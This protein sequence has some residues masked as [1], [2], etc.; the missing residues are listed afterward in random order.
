MSRYTK[1]DQFTIGGHNDENEKIATAINDTLSRKGDTPNAMEANLDMN[2]HRI[3]NLP[4]PVSGPEAATKQYV[5]DIAFGNISLEQGEW[6]YATKPPSAFGAVGDSIADDTDA[7]EAWAAQ[8]GILP[9]P[10]GLYKITRP[11]I[12]P[13]NSYIVGESQGQG[14][15]GGGG[16]TLDATTG[17]SV[18]IVDSDFDTTNGNYAVEMQNTTNN[19]FSG[20]GRNFTIWNDRTAGAQCGLLRVQAPYDS[21]NLSNCHFIFAGGGHEA[22]FI[23][24][25]SGVGNNLG[26]TVLLENIVAIGDDDSTASTNPVVRLRGINEFQMVGV[27]VFGCAIF[28]NPLRAGEA[29]QIDSCR[30]GTLVGC[31]SAA[32]Q[33]A[34]IRLISSYRAVFG[35]TISG[36]TYEQ[37]GDASLFID[38]DFNTG[39]SIAYI[40]EFAPRFEP[41]QNRGPKF[42]RAL[43]SRSETTF[44]SSSIDSNCDNCVIY[45]VNFDAV[46]NSGGTTNSVI[47]LPSTY[48]GAWQVANDMAV[49]KGGSNP[50]LY[51]HSDANN[52]YRLRSL[53]SSIDDFGFEIANRAN[54]S[55]RLLFDNAVLKVE[56]TGVGA[57][58]LRDNSGTPLNVGLHDNCINIGAADKS[59][60]QGV[61][62]GVMSTDISSNHN[63][64]TFHINKELKYTSG[65]PVTS[66][67]NTDPTDTIP[68]NTKISFL[69]V[70]AGAGTIQA[71]AG[72]TIN[73]VDGGSVTVN[74][75]DGAVGT[76]VGT[77][78]WIFVGGS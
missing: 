3:L 49:K 61:G 39:Q 25:V 71:S 38:G 48:S 63:I 42:V 66:T 27:K 26:Q 2:S 55:E 65:S 5:D 18:I 47:A 51:L 37:C 73:G 15:G 22:L 68:I 44:W 11:L 75:Y 10:R 70:G 35:I 23:D 64:T 33:G 54:T 29:I 8:G 20:G 31:S 4:T 43:T 6:P 17:A 56:G 32:T 72:V 60:S 13:N 24:G 77:D 40:Q 30:G 9:L 21:L 41:T 12:I 46:T 34:G 67:I 69:G 59:S 28:L 16:L 62:A 50:T 14:T 57:I 1:Q 45:A 76:K 58:N 36:H 53:T 7:M 74:Q 19:L 52:G 78:A